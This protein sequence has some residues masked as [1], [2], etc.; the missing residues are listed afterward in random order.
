ML[1]CKTIGKNMTEGE[2]KNRG[3]GNSNPP[4]EAPFRADASIPR[5]PLTPHQREEAQQ[6]NKQKAP[7]STGQEAQGRS[8]LIT[9]WDITTAG[10]ARNL[11]SQEQGFTGVGYL[12]IKGVQEGEPLGEAESLALPK[13]KEVRDRLNRSNTTSTRGQTSSNAP[14]TQ[15]AT[16]GST[17]Q[18]QSSNPQDGQG[19][20]KTCKHLQ[21]QELENSPEVSQG[22]RWP[23]PDLREHQVSPHDR[24]KEWPHQNWW[25]RIRAERQRESPVLE[26][27]RKNPGEKASYSKSRQTLPGPPLPPK[28][29]A[30]PATAGTRARGRSW[31]RTTDKTWAGRVPSIASVVDGSAQLTPSER[32]TS[33][34]M[35]GR[36]TS[37]TNTSSGASSDKKGR[38][39]QGTNP[40][41]DSDPGGSRVSKAGDPSRVKDTKRKNCQSA[42]G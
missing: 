32:T 25:Q 41:R 2:E 24:L 18:L 39:F 22:E 28:P 37:T 26:E 31:D 30:R 10:V 14:G 17:N 40:L 23:N 34:K 8:P 3:S 13:H 33:P 6:T 12:W 35:P 1:S 7:D 20:G 21:E 15:G 36:I 16:P 19:S 42:S 5:K 27:G 38:S 11:S 9:E 4:S 29:K